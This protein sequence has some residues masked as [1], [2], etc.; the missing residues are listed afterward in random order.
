AGILSGSNPTQYD[1]NDPFKLWAI[2][3]VVIVVV[4][5]LC[6]MLFWRMRQPRVVAEI[7]GG[8]VLGPTV[9]GR[10]PRFSATIFP[11]ESIPLLNL[12]ATLG[13]VLFL[14]LAGLEIDLKLIKKHARLSIVISAAGLIS[15]FA[16]GSLL[17]IP[18]YREFIDQTVDF[19]YFLLFTCISVGITAFPILC[20]M[21]AE[22]D[23]FNTT[24]GSVVLAAGVGNDVIGWILLALAVTLVN[25]T[26]GL[27]ALWIALTC[28]G[29]TVFLMYPVRWLFLWIGRKTGE[30]E[31]GDLSSVMMTCSIMMLLVSALFTDIIGLHAI[32]GGF[33]SGL[34]VPRER[35]LSITV[36]KRL[37][38][39]VWNIFLPVYFALSG[40]KTDLGLL[41]DGK[42]WG[43]T[44]VVCLMAYMGKFIGCG[45]ASRFLGFTWRESSAIG[46]LMSCKGLLELIVVNLALQARIFTGHVFAMFVV[47]AIV[48]T[49]V[50]TPLTGLIYPARFR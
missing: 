6:Y 30:L 41:N 18:L 8:I 35:Q 37:E 33:L 20:R 16:F 26:S 5:R 19:G 15:P 12:C 36:M 38:P 32:F 17:A 39:V 27:A 23:L 7:I 48:L 14:F 45:I 44:C 1:L 24:L 42:S 2:Q 28:A 47:H 43:F 40:L 29:Y 25:S 11:Q 31:T 46:T 49:V 13:L 9:M 21:L 4:S 50:I 10:I 34:V 3:V 22:L